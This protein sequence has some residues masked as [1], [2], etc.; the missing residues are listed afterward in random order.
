MITGAL[1]R[2]APAI[3]LAALAIAL[4]PSTA[5]A[6]PPN[7]DFPGT[8]I[9]S[10]PFTDTVDTAGA[11]DE[12]GEQFCLPYE[13]LAVWY[14]YT[15]SANTVLVADVEGSEYPVFVS[16]WTGTSLLDLTCGPEGD[17]RALVFQ[18]T[19]GVTYYF[20]VGSNSYPPQTG[21]LTFNS[22]QG[23]APPNDN[24]PGTTITGLPF[25]DTVD[26]TFATIEP[27]E[28][29]LFGA[30]VWYSY[31]PSQDMALVADTL[32][33]DFQT[34]ISVETEDDLPYPGGS[35]GEFTECGLALRVVFEAT[36][37][38]TYYFQ[39]G[40]RGFPGE[41]GTLVFNLAGGPE[42]PVLPTATPTPAPTVASLPAAGAS[43]DDGAGRPWAVMLTLIAAGA[44]ALAAL[45]VLASAALLLR[46]RRR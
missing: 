22:Q 24:F 11:T 17:V 18:A 43:P 19:A 29:A 1:I 38:Q 5:A 23:V 13:D 7:D 6:A 12:P 46:A 15:P 42:A 26:T 14:S 31:T 10:L 36:A 32:G 4:L 21:S 28:A 30:T 3:V 16:A 33:S 2:T 39:V 41:T 8:T 9:S 27:G 37:G 45:A 34:G 35:L 44:A 40:G 20:Q 25:S